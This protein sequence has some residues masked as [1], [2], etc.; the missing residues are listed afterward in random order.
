VLRAKRAEDGGLA[1]QVSEG[2]LKTLE[3]ICYFELHFCGSD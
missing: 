2:N 3:A 1:Y